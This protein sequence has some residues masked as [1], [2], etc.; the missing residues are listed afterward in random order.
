MKVGDKAHD[1]ELLSQEGE[2]IKLSAFFGGKKIIL[3]FYVKDE[4]RGC[5]NQVVGYS[6]LFSKLHDYYEILGVNDG[7]NESHA[8]FSEKF[9]IPFKLLS[10]PKK[11]V[12]AKYGAKGTLGLH[13]KR[14]TFLISMEGIVE[15]IIE[16]ANPKTHI[17]FLAT[18]K[19]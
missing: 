19:N 14:M 18:L 3:F 15:K 1:F 5:T 8:K 12:A 16:G 6:N 7:S 11:K 9:H 10:D 2:K 13:T 4:T 17:D